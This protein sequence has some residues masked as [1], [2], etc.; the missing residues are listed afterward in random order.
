MI[1]NEGFATIAADKDETFESVTVCTAPIRSTGSREVLLEL[2]VPEVLLEVYGHAVDGAGYKEA[3]IPVAFL[4]A[5]PL[6][7]IVE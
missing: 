1:L 4:T 3:S 5:I 7:R 6:P 2:E